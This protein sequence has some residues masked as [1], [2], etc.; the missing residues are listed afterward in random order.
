MRGRRDGD[1]LE[2][3]VSD[4]G[5]GISPA[6]VDTRS[7]STS[8]RPGGIDNTRERLRALYGDRASLT[9]EPGPGQGTIA[10]LRLPYRELPIESANAQE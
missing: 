8:L 7:P 6:I 3:T 10:T 4:D 5:I 2:L 9:V 1:T